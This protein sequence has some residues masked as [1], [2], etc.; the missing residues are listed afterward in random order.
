MATA[1]AAKTIAR[2]LFRL[3]LKP[4]AARSA[5]PDAKSRDLRGRWSARQT[6][7]QAFPLPLARP[8]RKSRNRFQ[9]VMAAL[10]AAISVREA[11]ALPI[12]MA[13]IRPAMTAHSASSA[14]SRKRE[15][16]RAP[17]YFR[18]SVGTSF[19]QAS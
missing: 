1:A 7:G 11:D 6:H 17:K 15:K 8:L 12:E 2:L 4:G 14:R 9:F 10:V 3:R 18:R 13:G 16:E 19:A 5:A